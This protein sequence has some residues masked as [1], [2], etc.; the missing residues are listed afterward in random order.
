MKRALDLFSALAAI[1]I[2]GPIFFLAAAAIWIDDR[3]PIFFVQWR[4]GRRG[5]PFRVYKFRT[6]RGGEGTRAGRWLRAAGLD[7]LPQYLNIV[8]GEMSVVGPRPLTQ[9]DVDRL[10]W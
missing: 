1:P 6:M 10:G 2:F 7:E 9:D 5:V 4:I 3:G 8:R